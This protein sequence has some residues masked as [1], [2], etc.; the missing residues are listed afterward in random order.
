L[1]CA[2][3]HFFLSGAI[4]TLSTVRAWMA[5]TCSMGIQSRVEARAHVSF[6]SWSI[7]A[8]EEINTHSGKMAAAMATIDAEIAQ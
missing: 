5:P 8:P 6:K 2:R 3:C 1:E 4:A 7:S